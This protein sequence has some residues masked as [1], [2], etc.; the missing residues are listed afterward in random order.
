MMKKYIQRYA[1][2]TLEEMDI[3]VIDFIV[4]TY[5]EMQNLDFERVKGEKE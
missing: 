3:G 2:N 5:Q 4:M 1:K